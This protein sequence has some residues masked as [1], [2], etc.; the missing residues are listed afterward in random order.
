[1]L[2]HGGCTN[3]H[4][5]LQYTSVPFSPHPYQHLLFLCVLIRAIL[6]G[7]NQYLVILICIYFMISDGEHLFVF[8]LAIV[9]L[10]RKIKFLFRSSAHFKSG[11]LGVFLLLS[12]MCPLYIFRCYSF[13]RN[14]IC[15]YFL[16]FHLID[17]FLYYAETF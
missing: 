17:G 6:I 16:P 4:S 9:F 1:M 15:K 14:M 2:F 7:V 12:C 10:L 5:L 11:F 8:L 3:L 13:I